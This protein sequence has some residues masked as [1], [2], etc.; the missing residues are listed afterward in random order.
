MSLIVTTRIPPQSQAYLQGSQVIMLK[1]AQR[2]FRYRH[3]K[4]HSRLSYRRL[5]PLSTPVVGGEPVG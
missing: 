4:P 1:A 3:L 2:G 5:S